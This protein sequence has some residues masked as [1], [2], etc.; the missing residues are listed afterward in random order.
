[1]V[2]DD[3]LAVDRGA[4]GGTLHDPGPFVEAVALRIADRGRCLYS[5]LISRASAACPAAPARALGRTSRAGAITTSRAER[6]RTRQFVSHAVT[7]I[8]GIAAAAR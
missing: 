6:L 2:F 7:V 1:M 4:V 3:P 8:V 5:T